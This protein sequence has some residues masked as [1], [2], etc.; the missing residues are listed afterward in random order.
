MINKRKVRP[1]FFQVRLDTEVDNMWH[2]K[3]WIIIGVAV[4][5]VVLAAGILGGVAYA[6]SPTP[7]SAGI[8]AGTGKTLLERVAT[9]LGIDQAKLKDAVNQAE[10]DMSVDNAKAFLDKQFQAG[11]ITQKQ[12]DDYLNWLKSKP[13]DLPANLGMGQGGRMGPMM[14]SQ[15]GMHQGGMGFGGGLPRFPGKVGPQ[16]TP[17]SPSPKVSPSATPSPS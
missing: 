12:E 17:G 5:V 3:K 4:A 8:G 1:S 11:K 9:I 13:A 7:S 6:Q 2:K 10:K 16:A 14:G 15:N